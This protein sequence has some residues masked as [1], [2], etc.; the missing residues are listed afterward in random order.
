LNTELGLNFILGERVWDVQSRFR[1]RLGPLTYEQFYRFMPVGDSLRPIAQLTRSYAGMEFDF[2]VQPVLRGEEVPWFR[3]I[4][5]G[6]DIPRLGWNTW[7]RSRP[8]DREVA[9][10][11]F[12]LEDV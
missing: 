9:D 1:L 6:A 7:V 2:D 5:D 10:A 8:F 3:L 12:S 11:I 4:A